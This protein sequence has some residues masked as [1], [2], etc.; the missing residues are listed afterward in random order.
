[1]DNAVIENFERMMASQT[2]TI[3]QLQRTIDRIEKGSR[4]IY[5]KDKYTFM[6]AFRLKCDQRGFMPYLIDVV[7]HTPKWQDMTS[8]KV[9]KFVDYISSCNSKRLNKPI[10][11]TSQNLYIA[12][13]RGLLKWGEMPVNDA[14]AVLHQHKIPQ[15]KK[16]WLHPDELE[17]I[18]NYDFT[19]NEASTWRMFML[20]A[21]IGCRLSDAKTITYANLD[22]DTVRYTPIKTHSTECYARLRKDQI[23]MFKFITSIENYNVEPSNTILRDIVMKSGI[24]RKFDVG[25]NGNKDIEFVYNLVHFHT[26]RHSFA[27]IKYRYSSWTERDIAIAVGHTNFNQTWTNYICDKS[28]VT[29]EDKDKK[30]LFI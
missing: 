16:V 25:V 17:K 12:Q 20:G 6:Q 7:G 8:E 11:P 10:Q 29:K 18:Y 4:T 1:M 13:L 19:N 14:K 30:G 9:G 23:K 24:S 22:G 3:K 26:A 28:P 21:L 5:N 2:K 15:R 27:T